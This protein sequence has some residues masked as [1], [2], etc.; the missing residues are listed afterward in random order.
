[1]VRHKQFNNGSGKSS[2]SKYYTEHMG[3][4]CYYWQGVGL[5]QG[6]TFNHMGLSKREMNLGVFT[7]LENNVN[8]E[9][10]ERITLQTNT[11]RQE[12]VVNS[13][14]G[15]RELETVGD[16][17]TGMDLPCIVPKTVSEVMA[18]NPGE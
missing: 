17:R 2:A 16:R 12:W 14:T 1:M 5:L 9:T 13:K 10:G 8:P 11:T 6:R 7:S 3:V 15:K 4:S 18:E